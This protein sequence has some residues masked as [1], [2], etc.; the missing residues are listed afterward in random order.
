MGALQTACGP[1]CPSPSF[2]L[3]LTCTH[4]F[5]L[6]FYPFSLLHYLT[7][8]F[9]L[10]ITEDCSKGGCKNG[11]LRRTDCS[12]V[13]YDGARKPGCPADQS[14]EEGEF[15]DLLAPFFNEKATLLL[16]SR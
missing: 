10:Q 16:Q 14:L 13:D 7:K 3:W 11:Y 6:C 12:V 5:T 2:P 9:D 15:M 4:S 8:Y 1:L